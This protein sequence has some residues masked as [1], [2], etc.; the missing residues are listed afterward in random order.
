MECRSPPPPLWVSGPN[1]AP[2]GIP[3]DR[4]VIS[5]I[6]G[7]STTPKGFSFPFFPLSPRRNGV[8]L[9]TAVVYS[10]DFDVWDFRECFDGARNGGRRRRG[11]TDCNARA[12]FG[13]RHYDRATAGSQLV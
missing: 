4:Q 11:Q 6:T 7:W 13:A 5:R 8:V 9:Y 12:P 10:S 1:G 2:R 3:Q